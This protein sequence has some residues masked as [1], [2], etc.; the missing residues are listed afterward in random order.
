MQNAA[1]PGRPGSPMPSFHLHVRRVNPGLSLCAAASL[2]RSH[3]A[4]SLSPTHSPRTYTTQDQEAPPCSL[5]RPPARNSGWP[6]SCV[7]P[8][9]L[10]LRP[11]FS[12]CRLPPPFSISAL[13]RV[14]AL[15]LALVSVSQP[16]LADNATTVDTG[17]ASVSICSASACLLALRSGRG[18]P[19]LHWLKPTPPPPPSLRIALPEPRGRL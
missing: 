3:L 5:K 16:V 12:P 15:S 2:I 14:R 13:T 10:V 1:A 19:F 4:P 9:V 7:R 11:E 17:E 8:C 6:R 18:Q